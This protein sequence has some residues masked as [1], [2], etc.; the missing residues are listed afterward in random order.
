VTGEWWLVTGDLSDFG[1]FPLS[2][3]FKGGAEGGG[4]GG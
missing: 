3:L 1:F 2:S 4:I